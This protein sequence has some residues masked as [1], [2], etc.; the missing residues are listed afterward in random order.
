MKVIHLIGGGDVGGAKSH[1][2]SL[3]KELSK[4][5]DVKLISFRSGIFADDARAMGINVEVIKSNNI[6]R[7]I[8]KVIRLIRD[9]KYQL[10]HS[11]GAKAN[12]I[13][14]IVRRFT[15]IP[16]VTTVHSDYR[17][18][19]LQSFIKR[20]SFG[21]INTIALRFIDY[22][23]GVSKN[24]KEMLVKRNFDADRIF[25]VYN[26]INF[27]SEIGTYRRTEFAAKFG[28]DLSDDDIAVGILARLTPVK[29]LNVFINAA[30]EVIKVNPKVKFLIGG[31]GEERKSLESKV[32]AL[33]LSNNFY[34]LG[35]VND[36]YEFMS[37]I[38]INTLTSISESFPYSIL[39]G[40]RLKK[41]TVSSNVG[42]LSDLIE[43]GQNG[44]LFNPGDYKKLSLYIL[45]LIDDVSL[46]N[47]MGEKIYL[48]A[49]EKFSL[50]NM[51]R[52]QLDIYESVLSSKPF[53]RKSGLHYD[54]I[55][56]GYYGFKNIGD[57]AML[58][59][60]TQN[61]R[62]YKR[63]ID[64]LVLSREPVE[65]TSVYDVNSIYRLDIFKVFRAM[66][67]S[68][69]FINGG[70]NLIQDNTSTRSLIYY[71]GMIWLAKKMGMKVMIYANGIGPINKK[72]NR[73]LTR[74]VLNQV[75]VITLR[76][77]IPSKCE[78]D[79]L[80]ISKPSIHI[81]ADPAL[82]IEPDGNE[83]IESI[84][85]NE[86]IDQNGPYI[87]I[88]VRKWH[89]YE[90]YEL[91]IAQLA[92]HMID[93][94]GLKPVFIPMHY[95]GDLGIIKRI[96][97][98]MNKKGYIINNKYSVLQTMGIIRKMDML[99]GMRLHA[100]IFAASQG[101]PVVGLE[102]EPKVEGFL[103][104]IKQAS[105][106]H[107]K[108]LELDNLVKTVEDVW[109]KKDKI[110]EELKSISSDLKNKALKNASIAVELVESDRN[111]RVN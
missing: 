38:D 93:N 89:G 35:F 66:R 31:E 106:G 54:I 34:F 59:A 108:D 57:D 110:K 56:S 69:L 9:E 41:A 105:V 12:M 49:R 19:Y 24:F 65:T 80:R 51:C 107:V 91:I 11:H 73:K 44:Y 86:G 10:I 15:K 64:I 104:A 14:V 84:F 58:M 52:T 16:T 68:K 46:R 48:K 32:N 76:E 43:H 30:K 20:L 2:L 83:D 111:H 87:G 26:G 62:L 50:K 90:K 101:I 53:E 1:V 8:K 100:L 33:G 81:T 13:A 98:K 18:D 102:Y 29:G 22:Y 99:I 96:V 4:H 75:D 55:I 79:N 71:L 95:P 94:F 63:D 92:D 42:G 67:H 61:L 82:T 28:I 7:D 97:G 25:T 78:I 85:S 27:D 6:I 36:P 39:E 103:K 60:I 45:K 72:A 37:S 88:S 3:V 74:M 17:L 77:E 5:I 109:N 40:T 70:G 23:I 47:E 21:I